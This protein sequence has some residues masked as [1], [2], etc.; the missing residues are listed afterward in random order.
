[1]LDKLLAA[2]SPEQAATSSSTAGREARG[3]RRRLSPAALARVLDHVEEDVEADIVQDLTE[4][5]AA[6]IL[7]LLEDGPSSNAFAYAGRERRRSDV[8]GLPR[9]QASLDG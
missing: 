1:V 2:L 8:T 6:A 3:P 7:P 9:A 5:Q 4:E